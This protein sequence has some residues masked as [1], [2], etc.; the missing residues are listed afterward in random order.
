MDGGNLNI[1]WDSMSPDN[2]LM[3]A[4]DTAAPNFMPK[5]GVTLPT[6]AAV[7]DSFFD[8]TNYVGAVDPNATSSWTD[9]WTTSEMN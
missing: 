3:K 1:A 8:T 6:A 2:V 4:F 5:A 9:G 7:N